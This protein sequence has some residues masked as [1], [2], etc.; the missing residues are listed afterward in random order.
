MCTRRLSPSRASVCTTPRAAG[1]LST[2]SSLQQFELSQ[3]VRKLA[4]L[5]RGLCL[6]ASRNGIS[7]EAL[8]RGGCSS[9]VRSLSFTMRSR[10]LIT[11]V[12]LKVQGSYLTA[13]TARWAARPLRQTI[14]ESSPA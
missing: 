7:R 11:T 14:D 6:C 5:R 1:W 8:N 4:T 13:A 2:P 10:S 3:Q 9:G 12:D